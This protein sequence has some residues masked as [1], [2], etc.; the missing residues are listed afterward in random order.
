[1]STW[2]YQFWIYAFKT[3]KYW[4]RGPRKWTA[5][6]LQFDSYSAAGLTQNQRSPVI[7][8]ET[9]FPE[10]FHLAIPQSPKQNLAETNSMT[11]PSSLCRWSIHACDRLD[12]E[13]SKTRTPSPEPVY[14][15]L[16]E[17]AWKPWSSSEHEP[18]LHQTLTQGLGSNH[19]SDIEAENLPVAL[20]KI[21]QALESSKDAFS[22]ET[23]G[24]SIMARNL[25]MVREILERE[26]VSDQTLGRMRP[27]HLAVTY[28]DGSRACCAVVDALLGGAPFRASDTNTL[29]HTVFDCLMMTILK[30]HT[31]VTPGEIDDGLRDEKSFPG[32]E[33]DIC[34]RFDADS[35]YVRALVASG[36]AGIP[37][38]WKHKFCHT[39]VQAICHSIV[40]IAF[41]LMGIEDDMITDVPSG[42]FLKKCVKCG[43]R[44]QMKPLHTLVLTAFKLG[45]FG[46][47]DEDLFGMIAILLCLLRYNVDPLVTADVSMA[48][49]FS[50]NESSAA[51]YPEC[52]HEPLRPRQVAELAWRY[53]DEWSNEV[54]TGWAIFCHILRVAEHVW[55]AESGPALRYIECKYCPGRS[56]FHRATNLTIL[57]AAV[58]TELLT[59]RRLRED[60]PWISPE[61]DMNSVLRS[62]ETGQPFTIDLIKEEKMCQEYGIPPIIPVKHL[63]ARRLVYTAIFPFSLTAELFHV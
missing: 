14:D 35:D 55:S 41:T 17:A 28:L 51:E 1:M 19:F 44:M 43:L 62:L 56:T 23:L 39:A 13:L 54:K 42:L 29:G 36:K 59:Y 49:L 30:A 38:S 12:Y 4:G 25:E 31:Y 32:E 2:L 8:V 20:P 27:L 18:S 5:G 21:V 46:A 24:F 61:F 22:E 16:D 10:P 34:G 63:S 47:K 33:V 53:V 57:H 48:A 15:C 50:G 52:S 11:K 37:F 40:A 60:D 7:D 45:Q 58:Q 9:I 3:A 26:R 6:L